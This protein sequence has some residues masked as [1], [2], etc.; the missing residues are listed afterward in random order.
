MGNRA[1]PVKQQDAR[2][3]TSWA[4]IRW[5]YNLNIIVYFIQPT[6]A[7]VCSEDMSADL[8]PQPRAR[9]AA[10]YIAELTADLARLARE[11]GFKEL[12]YLLEVARLEAGMKAGRAVGPRRPD[13]QR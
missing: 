2:G 10:G 4:I 1:P 12:A 6:R 8:P 5:R 7:D 11:S 3:S 13:E 9:D